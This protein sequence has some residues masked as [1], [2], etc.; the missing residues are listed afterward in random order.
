MPSAVAIYFRRMDFL[1]FKDYK[2]SVM[3][4]SGCIK[5]Q[6]YFTPSARQLNDHPLLLRKGASVKK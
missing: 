1:K 6:C 5:S 3:D 4:I 2:M